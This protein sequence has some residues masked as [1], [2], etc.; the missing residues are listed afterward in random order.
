M[1]INVM[2][3]TQLGVISSFRAFISYNVRVVPR[4]QL[5]F[6]LEMWTALL[7]PVNFKEKKNE[8]LL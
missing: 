7:Y 2:I 4:F 5:A 3:A 6:L 1:D 8:K